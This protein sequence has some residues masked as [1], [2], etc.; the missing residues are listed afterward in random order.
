M[1]LFGFAKKDNNTLS[2]PFPLRLTKGEKVFVIEQSGK[3]CTSQNSIIRKA[4][5]EYQNNINIKSE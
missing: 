1:S 4:L 3:E 2:E 5:S